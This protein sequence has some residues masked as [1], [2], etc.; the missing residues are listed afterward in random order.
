VTSGVRR[1]PLFLIAAADG[2]L[3]DHLL[4]HKAGKEPAPP[5]A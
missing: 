5:A 4:I 1:W 3:S 2:L